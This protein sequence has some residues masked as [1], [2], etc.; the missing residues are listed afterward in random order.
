[1]AINAKTYSQKPAEISR[2]WILIDAAEAPTLGRLSTVIATH[3]IGKNKVTYTPHTDNGDY[4]IVV[5]AEKVKVTGN[6]EEDKMYYRH[7]GFP[8]GLSEASLKELRAKNAAMIIEKSVQ[9]MLPKNKT[10]SERMKRLKVYNG[11]EHNHAAQK[12]QKVEVK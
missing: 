8:G 3:L 2:N 6:K 10:Q 1:M 12:P 7:S 4:V 5:N 9:G 11:T